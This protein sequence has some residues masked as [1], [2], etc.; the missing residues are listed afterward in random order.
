[1]RIA[2]YCSSFDNLPPSWQESARAVGDWIGA[3]HAEL[4]YGGVDLGLMH[5]VAEAT[6]A[7]GGAVCG[8][9]P[10]RRADHAYPANDVNIMA[11]GLTDR[12]NTMQLLADVFVMLPGG[13]GTL[14]EFASA[15][16]MINFSNLS[17]KR[18]VM[19]NPD[20]LYDHLLAQL[21][22][23]VERG[24]MNPSR[25][26]PLHVATTVAELTQTLDK[27]KSDLKL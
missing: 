25:M 13:Y 14:D 15:F 18:I 2:V 16:A 3:N 1:M 19:F 26:A 11:A 6:K 5:T 27:I 24:V 21:D 22:V 20:G 23:M 7:A 4:V 10:L 12:K 9:V 8:V 17:H